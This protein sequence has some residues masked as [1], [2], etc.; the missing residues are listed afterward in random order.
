MQSNRLVT[1]TEARSER[2]WKRLYDWALRKRLLREPQWGQAGLL[3]R[4]LRVRFASAL[5]LS[6]PALF[7]CAWYLFTALAA[8]TSHCSESKIKEPLTLSLFQLHLHDKLQREWQRLIMPEPHRKSALPTYGLMVSGDKLDQLD[9]HQPPDE[10]IA[11]Y[12]DGMLIKG[13]RVLPASLRYRGG[14]YWHYN[15]PQK[16]W[17]VRIKEGKAL[18]GLETFSLINTPDSV[19]FEEAIILGIA[20]EQGLLSPEYFPLRLLLNKAYMGVYFLEAQADESLLRRSGRAPGSIY[21]GSEAPV[22]PR[23]GVSMLFRSADYFT[24]VAQGPHQTLGDRRDLEAFIDATNRATLPEFL[25]YANQHLDLD[26]FALFDAL[27]VVFGCN[28]HDFG[29]HHKLYFDPYRS[30]FEPIA[31]NFHGCKHEAEFDRTENPLLLR[32][33]QLPDYLPRRNHQVYQLLRGAGAVESLRE[34]TRK[35]LDTLQADQA[36]DPYWDAYQLLPAMGPY[37]SQLLRPVSRQLQDIATETRLF[38]LGQRNRYLRESLERPQLGIAI[39]QTAG[40]K[41]QNESQMPSSNVAVIDLTARGEAAYRITQI[42]PDFVPG[43]PA[44]DWSLRADSNLDDR[45]EVDQDRELGRTRTGE[46][47]AG[48]ALDIHAGVRLIART[49]HPTRGMVRTVSEPRRYR[50]YLHSGSC[51]IVAAKVGVTNTVT[52]HPLTVAVTPNVN[53]EALSTAQARCENTYTDAP[54]QRSPHPWCYPAVPTETISIGP[55]VVDVEHTRSYAANQAVTIAPGTTLRM[56]PQASLIFRGHLDAQGNPTQPITFE[57]ASQDWGGVAIQGPGTAGSRLA[58]VQLLHGSHPESTSTFWPGTVNVQDTSDIT[59]R[60]CSL[61]ATT[62]NS[63]GLHIAD[64]KKIH[65]S[66]SR[67]RRVQGDAVD[68]DYS[69]ATLVALD[70]VQPMG[71]ALRA[72]GSELVISDSVLLASQGNAISVGQRSEVKVNDSLVFGSK[73]GLFVHDAAT[74]QYER[75]LLYKNEVGARLEPSNDWYA[76]KAHLKGDVLYAVGCK[77][78]VEVE[79]RRHTLQG[80]VS[81]QIPEQGLER[82]RAQILGPFAW[83]ELDSKISLLTNTEA[84]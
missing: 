30:R 74:I 50:F 32:L 8:Y 35:F 83:S 80:K 58:Y 44:E 53:A 21:S 72:Q 76:G 57:P 61:D 33:K 59:I 2:F 37:Y 60:H 18:E 6:S 64:A 19:P 47:L 7:L 63:V 38:E 16:S 70:L 10:G 41:G 49:P 55:G 39:T 4:L 13:S 1:V 43:C 28:Q 24:K 52:E 14:K 29:E 65:V 31:W 17:K 23:T 79:G 81:S 12:V 51:V 48:L 45:F 78:P 54:G 27:D 22:D 68:V 46:T 5:V 25:E 84:P 36:R 9:S 69:S 3:Q 15:H 40:A 77:V 71:D 26:K 34:R 62:A 67:F 73:C 75:V 42:T 20:R 66:H 56:A 11:N 82:L